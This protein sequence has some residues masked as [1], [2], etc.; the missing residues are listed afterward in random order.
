MLFKRTDAQGDWVRVDYSATWRYGYDFMLDAAQVILDD[1]MNNVQR[2]ARYESAG[3]KPQELLESVKAHGGV[4][5]KCGE[6]AEECAAIA[7][8]GISGIMECPIQITFYNQTNVVRLD[9]P[10]K[11]IFDEHG[12]R[13]FDNYMNSIEI[14]AYCADTE[15]RTVK[16]MNTAQR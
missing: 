1:F 11:K 14:K 9:C 4:L 10:V 16:A 7:V 5:A 6:L 3:K 8:A 13:V 12:E 2:V 15:R